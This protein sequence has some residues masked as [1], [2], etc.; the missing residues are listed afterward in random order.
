ML[1]RDWRRQRQQLR[2]EEDMVVMVMLPC[3]EEELESEE[4]LEEVLDVRCCCRGSMDGRWAAWVCSCSKREGSEGADMNSRGGGRWAKSGL[5]G[6][7]EV[8][9]EQSV[10]VGVM[11]GVSME[12]CEDEGTWMLK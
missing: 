12:K 1:A 10:A 7:A 9:L 5:V 3:R 6:S 11:F 2:A 4:L 8:W